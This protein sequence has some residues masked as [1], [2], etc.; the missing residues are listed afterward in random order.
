MTSEQQPP[1]PPTKNTKAVTKPTKQSV[2]I[3]MKK[4]T[5]SCVALFVD[6][7]L[8]AVR[9]RPGLPLV[10]SPADGE[11]AIEEEPVLDREEMATSWWLHLSQAR[12]A[13]SL[14]TPAGCIFKR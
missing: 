8:V 3:Q 2:T 6:D 12:S 4:L 14:A 7:R 10:A 5:I 9:N 11:L 1:M 13:W